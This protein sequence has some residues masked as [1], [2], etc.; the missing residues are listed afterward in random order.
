MTLYSW[1]LTSRTVEKNWHCSLAK[2]LGCL[3]GYCV[4]LSCRRLWFALWPGSTKDH[5][6]NGTNCLPTWHAGISLGVWHYNSTVQ[7]ARL[8]VE[9]S[10]GTCTK[11]ISWDQSQ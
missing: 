10:M 4:H 3:S 11:K 8:C 9:L 7:K 1:N 2:A 6:K 5:H